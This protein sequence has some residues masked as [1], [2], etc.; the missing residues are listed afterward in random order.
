MKILKFILNIIWTLSLKNICVWAI[1]GWHWLWSKTSIDEKAI[2]VVKETVR[3]SKNAAREMEDVT[4]A[5]KGKKFNKN[6]S[7]KKK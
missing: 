2:A 6:G 1:L 7:P 4:D 5:L 3:R